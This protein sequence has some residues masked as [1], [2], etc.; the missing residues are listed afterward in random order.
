MTSIFAA[1][2]S[3]SRT[4]GLSNN[5]WKQ[6]AAATGDA[7]TCTVAAYADRAVLDPGRRQRRG[8]GDNRVA[9]GAAADLG[10]QWDDQRVAGRRQLST[11]GD[12]QHRAAHSRRRR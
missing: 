8:Q 5:G 1:A 10:P 6:S 4:K 11:R 9:V 7:A 2:R 12:E 3:V